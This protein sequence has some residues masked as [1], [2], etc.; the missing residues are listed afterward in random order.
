MVFRERP[1][2][3][4]FLLP[5]LVSVYSPLA[6]AANLP[7]ELVRLHD[8]SRPVALTLAVSAIAWLIAYLLS[9]SPERAALV[10]VVAVAAFSSLGWVV[11]T[12]QGV[13]PKT[14]NV[15]SIIV[16]LYV[17]T[18]CSL[19][20]AL[21]LARRLFAGVVRFLLAIMVTLLVVWNVALVTRALARQG[22]LPAP[23]VAAEIAAPAHLAART[24]DIYVILLDKYT[25]SPVL[26]SG[27][28]FDNRPFE[29]ALRARGFVVP[30]DPRANYT[31]TFLALAAML[32]VRYLDDLT[33]HYG[34]LGRWDVAYPLIEN[35]RVAAFLR[36]HGYRVVTFPSEFGGTRQ[37]RY[38][39]EQIPAP[40]A[41]RSEVYA[42]WFHTTAGPALVVLWCRILGCHPYAPPYMTGSVDL[43][44]WRFRAL[45]GIPTES[46]RPLFVFAHFLVPH[47]PYFY[48]PACEHRSPYWPE[49][50]DLDPVRVRQD[51]LDQIQCVNQKVLAAVDA[52]SRDRSVVPPI[53][54]LQGDHGHGRLGRELPD[55]GRA[56]PA[57]IRERTSVFAAYLL[58]G[59][60]P[61][62]VAPGVTA[63][64]VVRLI[65]R[66]Y[67][68]ADSPALPVS[69]SGP[70]RGTLTCTRACPESLHGDSG[71]ESADPQRG[72]S[73]TRRWA[74]R[75]PA[76]VVLLYALCARCLERF[77]SGVARRPSA[78][79][80]GVIP[81]PRSRRASH[82]R[83]TTRC[84]HWCSASRLHRGHSSWAGC[85]SLP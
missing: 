71:L 6:I 79:S 35:S 42:A 46:H 82:G 72:D 27:F 41:V 7:G 57:A 73:R 28:G 16:P 33:A 31:H 52:P 29:E 1:R 9:R 81:T 80:Q 36:S 85:S 30:S 21:I 55:I 8:F 19:T 68:R 39:H 3:A 56:S 58:P 45:A 24:P 74:R 78:L 77:R 13:L 61:D 70:L 53:I 12:L 47:E 50:D 32:N 75:W 26:A 54:L 37:N 67:F 2:L 14:I 59:L 44:D 84:P 4:N 62:S 23:P 49:R 25:G 11:E 15:P 65:L 66:H 34:D 10:T 51:Y 22:R 5:I 20:A 17:I 43:M 63:V 69:P 40:S 18:M 76:G 60:P 83:C 38:A 48:G 64:N